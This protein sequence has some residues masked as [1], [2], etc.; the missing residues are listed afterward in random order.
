MPCSSAAATA[1]GS[2][3]NPAEG[4]RQACP[5][6]ASERTVGVEEDI[7]TLAACP[8]EEVSPF[9]LHR[10]D[11]G[12]VSLVTM[13]TADAPWTPGDG[14]RGEE[15]GRNPSSACS[16]TSVKVS[17]TQSRPRSASSLSMQVVL[18]A[19]RD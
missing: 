15:E 17:V 6:D 19:C 16:D 10:G 5:A 13:E 7:P 12:A 18:E 8:S 14:G 4:P 1:E 2:C 11:G 9:A 3:A